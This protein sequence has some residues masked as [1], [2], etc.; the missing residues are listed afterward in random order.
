MGCVPLPGAQGQ[1]RIQMSRIRARSRLRGKSDLHSPHEGNVIS[2]TR[3]GRH[4]RAG[5]NVR[6]ALAFL[7]VLG[8]P[9]PAQA[10]A[11]ASLRGEVRDSAGTPL[12]A[13]EVSVRDAAGSLV[14]STSTSA[15]G[16]YLLVGLPAGDNYTVTFARL[17]FDERVSRQ[18]ILAPGESRRL[19]VLLTLRPLTLDRIHVRSTP[20]VV[21]DPARTGAIT[22]LE[23]RAVATLPTVE[24][25]LVDL[26]ALS[27]MVSLD[28]EAIAVG[29]QNSRL[30]ALRIDGALSQDLFG[31]SPSG[32][33]GGQANAKALPLDAIRQ[34]A[35]LVAPFDV[36][37]SG[38][39]GGL[40]E[41]TTRS[42]GDRWEARGFAYYRDDAFSG[43][44]DDSRPG[45]SH[46]QG[47]AQ[48]F[49]TQTA[50][51][52]VGGPV[53]AARLFV[54]GEVER[55]RRP[56]PGFHLDG[57][58]PIRLALEADSVN[59][60]VSLLEERYGM[61][62]GETGRYDLDNPLGN[63]FARIDA[64]L[65]ERHRMTLRY[66]L[67]T[68]AEDRPPARLG[69]DA[70][71]LGSMGTR[72]ESATHGV[73]ARMVSR[74]SS[75]AT[76]ELRVNV[77]RSADATLA[78]SPLPQVEV[79]LMGAIDS[80]LLFRRVQAGGNPLA[81]DNS[82][83]QSIAQVADHLSYRAGDHLLTT[84]VEGSVFSVR[85][86]FLPASRGIWRFANLRDLAEDRPSSFERL[87]LAP[88]ADPDA[89]VSLLQVG[90]YVQ[91]DWTV[92]DQLGLTLGVRVDVPVARTRPAHNP[93]VEATAGA[94]TDRVPSGSPLFSPRLGFNWSPGWI[95]QTQLRG[96]VGLFA[97]VPPLTW[98]ADAY[99][100]DGMRTRF[101]HCERDVPSF[102]PTS[103]PDACPD[104]GGEVATVTHFEEGFRYP[105]D[106]RASIA[107]DQELPLG[108]VGTV[109]AVYTRAMHQVSLRDLNLAD[110]GTGPYPGDLGYPTDIGNRPIFGTPLR[111]PTRFGPLT[112]G[113]LWSDYGHVIEVGNESRNAALAVAAEVQRRFSD[114][115]DLRL[116][117]TYT[118]AI[119]TRSLLYESAALNYG[120]TPVRGHPTETEPRH[121][122]FA[123]PHR[124]LASVWTRLAGWGG[125]LDASLLYVG[126]SGTPY[127]YVFESDMNGDGFPGPGA[128][129]E[130]YNDLIFA[131][132]LLSQVPGWPSTGIMLLDLVKRE[133]C[134]QEAVN[135]ILARN[136]CR[137]PWSN[138]LDVRLAQSLPLGGGRVQLTGDLLNALNLLDRSWGLVQVAPAVVPIL[139]VDRRVGCP[140]LD[141][142][143]R[144]EL[145]W[146]YV[147]PR[148]R[149]MTRGRTR[150]ALPYTPL[151]PESQWRAQLG[152]RVEF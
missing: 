51:F 20:A 58:D 64:P 131:P 8:A 2:D 33:P 76:N 17:G 99:A 102:D 128:T 37:H 44:A 138:R 80:A 3:A 100:E 81:H 101:V 98:I 53:G 134:L 146:T 125:G 87:V 110:P 89:R 83:R 31:L 137:T 21:M 25:D 22:V 13:V 36:R 43:V 109:E 120:M 52:T 77:H 85:R 35:V 56:I 6:A 19:D 111:I 132:E 68:A 73:A 135:G 142:S 108:L 12:V 55:R 54:A 141:C 11:T 78:R 4:T 23:E 107:V 129:A 123:R 106:L 72:V 49:R 18:I 86:R 97:G 149:D 30:N 46:G 148:E 10:Q 115:L 152:V 82:L 124:V 94:D 88:G 61:D 143:L 95:R 50:G 27:P 139:R 60:M 116:A 118:R 45:R 32:V 113:R 126:Q 63:L 71:Q 140:G 147:G 65:G 40:L 84:G 122:A 38:F 104:G 1:V 103:P 151:L 91:D 92:N 69:F 15:A 133:P 79:R 29:G 9:V 57:A 67:I 75:R 117:Y 144:N 121:A 119:D 16:R 127:S 62:A 93:D 136:V 39:T 130:A 48:D 74:L 5:L 14:A 112:P 114:R 28:G 150:A 7:L 90:G 70:Y 59:R 42:G 105:Q 34:Y 24:R 96:G 145:I 26:A 66:N 41:A 47:V